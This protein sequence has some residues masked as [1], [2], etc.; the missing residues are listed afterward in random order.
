MYLVGREHA[1]DVWGPITELGLVVLKN[2]DILDGVPL[3]C[4]T[5]CSALAPVNCG[6]RLTAFDHQPQ[7]CNTVMAWKVQY[8]SGNP[9]SSA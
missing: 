1:S 8:W 4:F 6:S 2:E 5:G 7:D 9:V 3:W